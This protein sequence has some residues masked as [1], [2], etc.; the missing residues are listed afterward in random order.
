MTARLSTWSTALPRSR[1]VRSGLAGLPGRGRRP[2]APPTANRAGEARF[3]VRARRP[4]APRRPGEGAAARAWSARRLVVL[5][6]VAWQP[7]RR[8][9]AVGSAEPAERTDRRGRSAM[10]PGRGVALPRPRPDRGRR[11]R[12]RIV[13]LFGFVP[14]A[15]EA[16]AATLRTGLRHDRAR[17]HRPGGDVT[18]PGSPRLLKGGLVLVDPQLRRGRARHRAAVQPRHADPHAAGARR[19]GEGGDRSRGAAAEGPAGRDDQARGRDRRHRPARVP[20]PEPHRGRARHP[21]AARRARD[22]RL[23]DERRSCRRN[24]AL[25]RAGHARDRADASAADA[26]R[27][28]QAAASCRCGSPTSAI[29]EEAFDPALNPIRAKVSLGM[30]VLCVDDL[31]FDAQGRQ[32]VHGLPAE[33]GAARRPRSA[34]AGARHRRL[35]RSDGRSCMTR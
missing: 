3:G 1:L 22:A 21:P 8:A 31:G 28:E 6:D 18:F 29:T 27:L 10:V 7:D 15:A 12:R 34:G 30:R 4:G 23:P 20:R 9:T 32:P 24:N 25:A 17:P 13:R 2:T 26:V 19:G 16:I 14:T 5:L 11:V 35:W 33:Q